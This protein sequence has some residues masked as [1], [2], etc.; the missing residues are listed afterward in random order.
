MVSFGTGLNEL[1]QVS[2]L[3][4]MHSGGKRLSFDVLTGSFQVAKKEAKSLP[5]ALG[6]PPRPKG[7]PRATRNAWDKLT[8]E[9]LAARTLAQSD[10]SLLLSLIQARAEQYKCAGAKKKAAGKEVAR[11][12]AIWATRPPFVERVET[13]PAPEKQA[14]SLEAFIVG[15][16]SV[17][18]SFQSRLIPN[19]TVCK[20]ASGIFDWAPEHA[21]SIARSY[22]QK[23]LQ[24]EIVAGKNVKLAAQRFITDLEVGHTRGFF[25]DPDEA[26]VIKAWF[27]N[28]VN[29][30]RIQPWQLFCVV[31]LFAFK[32]ASGLRRF[33][34][35]WLATG[36]KNGKSNFLA[37]IGAFCLCA[38]LCSRPEIY[39]AAT[40]RDQAAI[41]W[42]DAKAI[43]RGSPELK[44]AVKVMA[45]KL[46]IEDAEA[47]FE[48]L[49]SDSH[50]MDGLRVQVAL[51]D[52]IHE[53]PSDAVVKR[54]QSGTLSRPQPLVI[55]ATTAGQDRDS[56]AY[57]QHEMYER[58]L[59]GTTEDFKFSDERFVYIAALDENDDPADPTLWIKANP[60]LGIS[61]DVE[62]LKSQAR[63]FENDPNSRF[64]FLRFHANIWNSVVVG[65]S[66]PQDKIDACVGCPMPAG[67]A[68]ELRKTFLAK[69][70]QERTLFFGG[71]D[72]GLSDDT[73]AFSLVT[74]HFAHGY[75]VTGDYSKKTAI[76]PW[77]W[78]NENGLK[79][80]ELSWRVP[81]SLWIREGWIKIAGED[82][83]DLDTVERD[84]KEICGTYR[85]PVVGFDRWKSEV[86]C[87]RL[88]AQNV[89]RF[90]A[91]PQL[92]SI[93][94]A[95]SQELKL[96][97]LKGTVAHLNNPVLR[98]Q[99]SNVSLEADEKHGG[100][101]PS[102]AGG[103]NRNKIDA[104]QATVTGWQ[105]LLDP[106]NRKYL[107]TPKIFML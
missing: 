85:V 52:E 35:F 67:G 59:K 95:P 13:C 80:K 102:K 69:A 28:Y 62:G 20:S 57:S 70:A 7:L 88:L 55:S 76:V 77:V 93:L 10:A 33:R 74:P 6:I 50:T 64:S 3:V 91:V 87:S 104:I 71:I 97:I 39:S 25:F 34:W 79:D 51:C 84:I 58:M 5:F 42:K 12:E 54:L 16:R 31:S 73:C 99:L 78:M 36:R 90:V 83:V 40:K 48:A 9:L 17:R 18:E 53:H 89:A 26:A 65:H 4:P 81:L 68:M 107:N 63:E 15:V 72:I 19:E 24:G 41:I 92:P 82:M 47:L 101:K 75:T 60:N 22:A 14:P 86:M 27:D 96:G 30:W 1:V 32:W 61:V 29:D 2:V 21:A 44:S 11:L 23:V 106:L 8:A 49:G 66:L 37:A 56:Y 38:D 45:R 46:E 43:V 98:W 100:I 94:T 103:E 105:Q